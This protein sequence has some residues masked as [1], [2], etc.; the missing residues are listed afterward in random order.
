MINPRSHSGDE[1][2]C[3]INP[4]KLSVQLFPGC[5]PQDLRI[6]LLQRAG[7]VK[8]IPAPGP[9]EGDSPGM[10]PGNLS[11]IKISNLSFLYILGN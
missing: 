7:L 6:R 1:P 8:L 3:D 5:S 10:E 4:G 9:A 11:F 2:S